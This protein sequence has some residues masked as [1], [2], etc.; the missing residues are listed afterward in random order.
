VVWSRQN[1]H[2][3]LFATPIFKKTEIEKI[4]NDMLSSG[5]IRPSH[6]PFSSPVLLV[7]KQDGSWRLSS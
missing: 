4:V 1:N 7:R 5:I 2:N 6:S 3:F